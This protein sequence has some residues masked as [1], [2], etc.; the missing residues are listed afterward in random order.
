MDLTQLSARISSHEDQ[1]DLQQFCRSPM[2]EEIGEVRPENANDLFAT[3]IQFLGNRGMHVII[4]DEHDNIAGLIVM[5]PLDR[6]DMG[7][8][9]A[10][11]LRLSE[12]L[13]LALS[14]NQDDELIKKFVETLMTCVPKAYRGFKCKID[15]QSDLGQILFSTLDQQGHRVSISAGQNNLIVLFSKTKPD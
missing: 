4:T 5:Q 9:Q 3:Q 6:S 12:K 10:T 2:S 15:L 1:R 7:Y 8:A 13:V 11:R 14:E